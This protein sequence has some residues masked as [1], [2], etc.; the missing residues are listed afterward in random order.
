MKKLLLSLATVASFVLFLGS[1]ANEDD[2]N[3]NYS[4]KEKAM[5]LFESHRLQW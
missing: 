2:V 3:N 5:N 4:N 1:C